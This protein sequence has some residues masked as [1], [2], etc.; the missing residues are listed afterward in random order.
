MS[1][2][3][4]CSEFQWSNL[5]TEFFHIVLASNNGHLI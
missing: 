3:Y 1:L 4:I 5:D 2:D